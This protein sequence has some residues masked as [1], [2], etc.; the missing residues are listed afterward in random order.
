M[1]HELFVINRRTVLDKEEQ[2]RVIY[3]RDQLKIA[4]LLD[5]KWQAAALK[6]DIATIERGHLIT[7]S[8]LS[9][10]ELTIWRAW[11]PTVYADNAD[12]HHRLA[13]YHFDRIPS[14]VLKM[15]KKHKESGFFECFEI[16]TPEDH[17][18]DPILIGVNGTS[19]HLLARWGE[20]DANFVSFADIKRELARR[21]H[22]NESFG[23]E[24]FDDYWRRLSRGGNAFFSAAISFMLILALVA[25][26][27]KSLT[28]SPVISVLGAVS[29]GLAFGAVAFR[30]VWRRMTDKLAR[31][32]PLMRAIADD[33]SIQRELLTEST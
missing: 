15:W 29:A 18:S 7:T 4:E 32:S 21:W 27:L 3:L 22:K 31:S 26:G 5:L 30:Y 20:S 2:A 25:L 33:S 9:D 16:W 6:A 13:D 17:Q 28:A 24:P 11:L 19:R 1:S 8:A 14:P 23:N 10:A 12:K